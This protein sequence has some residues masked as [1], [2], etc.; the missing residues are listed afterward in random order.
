[1]STLDVV[2]KFDQSGALVRSFGAGLMVFP[3]GIHVDRDGNVWLTD[4]QDNLPRR[5]RG[6]APDA[7]L[8]PPPAQIVGH[9]D[10]QVQP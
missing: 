9:A 10:L 6:E 4:G 8:P 2:L 1:M 3:H 5:G 7:P